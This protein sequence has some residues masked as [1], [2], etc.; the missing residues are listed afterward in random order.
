MT[1]IKFTFT[2]KFYQKYHYEPNAL[3][4]HQIGFCPEHL[5]GPATPGLRPALRGC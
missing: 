4:A 5:K 1:I 2:G 3:S